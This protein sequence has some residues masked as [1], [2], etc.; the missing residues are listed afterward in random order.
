VQAGLHNSQDLFRRVDDLFLDFAHKAS[1]FNSWF[2][3]AEEDLTDPVR[4]NSLEEIKSLRA[5]HADFMQSLGAAEGKFQQLV[6]L[7]EKIRSYTDAKNPYTWFTIGTL[8]ESWANLKEVI[9]DR[10]TDLQG[11]L[12]RQEANEELRKLFAKHANEFS[13]WLTSTRLALVEGTGTLEEQL[14][15]TK[16]RYDEVLRKKIALKSIEELGARMEEALILDNRYTEHSTV[17]LAQQWDQLEQL[18]MRMQHNL[19]QQIQAKNTTGVSEE[20]LKEFNETF[21]YFDKDGSGQLDH[22][23]LKSCLRSLGYS[24]PVVEEG[25]SDPEF[26]AI[27]AQ[28]DPSGDGYVSHG[29]FMSFMIARETENVESA[30]E[31]VSAFRA[32]AGDKPYVTLED[33]SR[34]LT[35]DQVDYCARHMKPYVEHGKAVAGAFDYKT[36]THAIFAS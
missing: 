4:V 22:Q 35:K 19:E 10:S 23:E 11:E 7:D 9:E 5:M 31:V 8:Q 28:L 13:S 33:L 20:Q 18:G 6:A 27:L 25:Q 29:E 36:F 32:A 16:E 30:S 24:L 14:A 3:N 12:Q 34:A 21:R 2:E 15:R 17:G 26:A 1:Q